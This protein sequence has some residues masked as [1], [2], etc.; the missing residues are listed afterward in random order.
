MGVKPTLELYP[1]DLI[2]QAQLPA[3]KAL[4]TVPA[5]QVASVSAPAQ[6][7]TPA[8]TW[9]AKRA[10]R[11]LR[12]LTEMTDAQSAYL[13]S[14]ADVSKSFIAAAR[15]ANEVT[16][17]PEICATDT[18]IRGLRRERDF[19]NART[20]L[21]Q[22]RYGFYATQK[23]VDKLRKPKIKKALLQDHSASI[24][25]LMKTKIDM[26]SLGEDTSG[27]DQTLAMLQR[28]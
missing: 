4:V 27:I 8:T 17:L 26:E 22:A 1:Q 2:A 7:S 5:P 10:T 18:Q 23:E 6:F 25:A 12:A 24:D 20:E 13:R 14:R 11:Y 19:L 16:E 9:G 3:A 21:E 28:A 15:A